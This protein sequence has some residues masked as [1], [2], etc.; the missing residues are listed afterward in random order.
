M[1]EYAPQRQMLPLIS[2]RMSSAVRAR[3]FRDHA[4]SGADLSGRAVAALKGILVDERLLDGMQRLPCRE[5]FDRRHRA[6]S[7]M[8][9]SVRQDRTRLPSRST[10]HAPHWP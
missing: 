10:V 2:S 9:A 1:F 6:P 8:I 3:P 7:F 5:P 4:H